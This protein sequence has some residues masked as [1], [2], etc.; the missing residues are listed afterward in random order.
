MSV[1]FTETGKVCTG[2]SHP[3]V[4][5]YNASAGTITY[6]DAQELARGVDVSVEPESSDTNK[7][8]ANNQEAESAPQ[9]FTGGTVTLTVDGLLKASEAMIMGLPEAE[10]DGWSEYGDTASAPYVGIGYIARYMSGGV[11][12]F[13]PTIIIKARF[14]QISSSAATQEDAIDWQTQS[15]TA[16]IFRADDTN[17]GWKWLGDD[18]AT[19]DEALTAMKTKLGVTAG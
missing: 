18:F 17:H 11:E 14:Q 13:V 19:E 10:T 3:W 2:F 1:T 6:S 8:Y 7:F 9:R 4:A 12:S 16:D 15:L 5:K